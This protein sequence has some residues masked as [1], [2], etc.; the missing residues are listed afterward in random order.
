MLL[1]L[2]LTY[3]CY[4]QRFSRMAPRYIQHSMFVSDLAVLSRLYDLKILYPMKMKGSSH[5][6]TTISGHIHLQNFQ[7][8]RSSHRSIS[9]LFSYAFFTSQ[10][11]IHSYISSGRRLYGFFDIVLE[12]YSMFLPEKKI[13]FPFAVFKCLSH[14]FRSKFAAMLYKLPKAN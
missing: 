7:C 10:A 4:M 3:I 2:L 1:Y 12:H 9:L 8:Y 6:T 5:L 13:I 14:T 11:L